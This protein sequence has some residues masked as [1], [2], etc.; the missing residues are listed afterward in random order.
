MKK[1]ILSLTL[2][3]ALGAALAFA[4]DNAPATEEISAAGKYPLKV[5]PV[6]GETLGE[7]GDP[8]VK[9]Y[10]GREV[11]FC[12]KNCV[13][14]FEK[15]LASSMQILDNKIYEAEKAAYPLKTCVV[16]GETLGEMGDPYPYM[17]KN[18]LVEFCCQNC[19]STFEK[20]PDKYLSM[21][22]AAHAKSV[23]PEESKE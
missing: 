8:V 6:S 22:Y 14:T 23:E 20:D 16:S 12:C 18:Q 1:L 15:D 7:M 21:I 4:E 3:L 9:V 19:V 13:G 2:A 10:D 5:C 11:K 17:Y